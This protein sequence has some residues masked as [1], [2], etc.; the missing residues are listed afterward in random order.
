MRISVCLLSVFFIVGVV[1][2]LSSTHLLSKIEPTLKKMVSLYHTGH[3]ID[4][5]SAMM[6]VKV[7]L[8]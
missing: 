3:E 2:T 1:S 5:F 7:R 8:D 6:S 4:T